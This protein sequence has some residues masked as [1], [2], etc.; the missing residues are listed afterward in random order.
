MARPVRCS[1]LVGNLQAWAG[2]PVGLSQGMIGTLAL[3][4]PTRPHRVA[5]AA[6]QLLMLQHYVRL[7]QR[8]IRIRRGAGLDGN[9]LSLVAYRDMP[10]P[11]FL[12]CGAGHAPFYCVRS[13]S[14]VG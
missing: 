6:L 8:T 2:K 4:T 10:L 12:A 1:L 9:G 5:G 11:I 14:R 3:P 13:L 7:G